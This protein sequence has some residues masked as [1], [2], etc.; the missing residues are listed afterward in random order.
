MT[1]FESMTPEQRALRARLASHSSWAQTANRRARTKPGS[2]A[3]LAKLAAEVDPDGLMSPEDRAKA[4][5]N[6]KS[7]YFSRLALKAAA[8]RKRG[9]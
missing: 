3:L 4:V 9:T 2:Q 7:A 5:E 1:V 8:A 6:A